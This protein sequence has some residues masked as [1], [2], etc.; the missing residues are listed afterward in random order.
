MFSD[1]FRSLSSALVHGESVLAVSR[2]HCRNAVGPNRV[3]RF[4][5]NRIGTTGR[6]RRERSSAISPGD[7]CRPFL[8]ALLSSRFVRVYPP[9][10]LP[11]RYIY[12]C[13]YTAIR[14]KFLSFP[15]NTERSPN[16]CPFNRLIRN[17]FVR[18]FVYSV[19]VNRTE[20]PA[21][22]YVTSREVRYFSFRRGRPSRL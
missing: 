21:T 20:W 13:V 1:R 22:N 18:I 15:V 8:S 5:Q 16:R 11:L 14:T 2:A 19:P 6:I 10:P 3:G 17:R 9:P 7:N 12:I 4:A